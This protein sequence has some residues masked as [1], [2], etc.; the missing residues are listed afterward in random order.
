MKKTLLLTAVAVLL[1]T[2][3]QAQLS[4][5]ITSW[6]LN[7]TGATGYDG[8]ETNVQQ[9]Q[10]SDSFVYVSATCIPGYSIG[11]WMGSPATPSNQNF[12]FKIPRFLVPNTGTPVAIGGGHEATLTNG[13]SAFGATDAH[14]YNNLNVWQ[15]NGYHF[16]YPS[17][18][19]CLGHPQ[20][21]GEYHHHVS[22]KCLY[23]ITDSTH[24]S[25]IIGYAY[26][27]YPIY[28]AYGYANTSTA[29]GS[30]KRMRS[31]FYLRNMV[32]R[33]TLPDGTVLTPTYY[34]PP[35][36]DSFPLGSYIPGCT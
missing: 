23:S 21:F 1:L 36:S 6:I 5:D 17:F 28:G 35:V 25:P 10:Y 30:V 12:V 7:T 16:E 27:G 8:I 14:T 22:P 34:G 32:N 20:Q 18:D 11:P 29:G 33:D 15:Q 13:V 24:H 19:A 3:A 2:N 9:V 4:P 26:D 31:G